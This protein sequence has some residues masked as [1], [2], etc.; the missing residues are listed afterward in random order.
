MI[1]I[2]APL[3]LWL[4]CL[5][6]IVGAGYYGWSKRQLARYCEPA[7]QSR[8]LIAHWSWRS[9][10]WLWLS[11][12]SVL[13]L[14]L[15]EPMWVSDNTR[16]VHQPIQWTAVVDVSDSMLAEDVAP[17]R[18]QSVRWALESL[19][20]HWQAGDQAGLWV[21]AGSQHALIPQTKDQALWQSGIPLLSPEMMPLK[22]SLL[23]E[24]LTKLSTQL[25]PDTFILLFTDGGEQ[26]D[27]SQLPDQVAQRGI[28]VSLGTTTGQYPVNQAQ[29]TLL[30]K[31]LGWDLLSLT[32]HQGLAEIQAQLTQQRLAST[33]PAQDVTAIGTALQP[34]LIA[35]ALLLWAGFG[36]RPS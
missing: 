6:L 3:W 31:R 20:S 10:P 28:I 16:A 12:W 27:L 13:V 4:W 14:A 33:T 36:R 17:N 1:V 35:L 24:T 25:N 15:A 11:L 22:G 32:A 26:L 23:I 19:G 29:L 18:L 34:W 21:F 2:H 5:P 7:L 30:A 8:M 9:L